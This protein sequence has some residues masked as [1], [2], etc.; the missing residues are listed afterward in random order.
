MRN[1][2]TG[3]AGFIGSHLA[4]TLV[5][6]GEEVAIV[7]DLSTG[8]QENIQHLLDSGSVEFIQGSVSDG[9]LVA[10]L[11][12][13]MD[14]CFH[15]AS[16]VGVQLIVD[17]PLR[18]LQDNVRGMEIVIETAARQGTRLLVAS[19]SEIYGKSSVGALQESSDRLLGSPDVSRWTY[20][21]AKVYG[22]MLAYGY[23]REHGAPNVVVR[24]FNTVGPR[25]SGMYGMVV[26]RFVRQ[27]LAGEDITVYG[28]GSQSRCFTHVR[29]S[30]D[31][32]IRLIDEPRAFGRP[33]NVGHHTEVTIN[34]LAEAVRS[35]V[36]ADSAIR[37][38]PYSEAYGDGFEELGRRMP[39]TAQIEELTGWRSQHTV[40]QAIVDIVNYERRAPASLP[41]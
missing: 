19:T 13:N 37:H 18:T 25:Q 5:D 35:L 4:D 16:A 8:R 34:E 9:P 28:D 12:R 1:L 39:N 32:M 3:G 24:F 10:D 6:R 38:V 29:D 21:N 11:M 23:H 27:A 33:F 41:L 36:G 26:P 30:I 31:A 20:A 14:R 15:L 7:D 40:E 17:N 22:E 2:I